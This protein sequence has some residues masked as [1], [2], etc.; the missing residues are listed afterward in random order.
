MFHK[1]CNTS[2]E[3][4]QNMTFVSFIQYHTFKKQPSNTS[5]TELSLNGTTVKPYLLRLNQLAAKP[6]YD[7]AAAC[8][9]FLLSFAALFSRAWTEGALFPVGTAI[10]ILDT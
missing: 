6:A 5:S 1:I 4:F 9:G 3:T 8:L 7:T 10:F 2:F